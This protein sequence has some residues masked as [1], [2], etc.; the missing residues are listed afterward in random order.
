MSFNFAYSDP[1]CYRLSLL[2]VVLVCVLSAAILVITT[3][4]VFLHWRRVKHKSYV[5]H[6][7]SKTGGKNVTDFS[8]D[9]ESTSKQEFW[10]NGIHSNGETESNESNLS[11]VKTKLF[12]ILP[13]KAN[14]VHNYY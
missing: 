14:Q 9:A 6:S 12:Y 5:E 1:A 3:L 8:S 10:Q 2:L 13:I 11:K 4:L 7:P